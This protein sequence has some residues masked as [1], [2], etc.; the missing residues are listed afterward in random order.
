V[1]YF[2]LW[3]EGEVSAEKSARLYI[4]NELKF[5]T[6]SYNSHLGSWDGGLLPWMTIK[7]RLE[8]RDLAG[9]GGYSFHRLPNLGYLVAL[10]SEK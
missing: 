9:G 10:V 1:S 6:D 7:T 8:L 4:D 3:L 2:F 5:P